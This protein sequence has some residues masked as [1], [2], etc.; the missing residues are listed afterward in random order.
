MPTEP[1]VR[2]YLGANSPAGFYSLYDEL[3][4]PSEARR[5]LILKGG[6]GCGKST[7]MGQVARQ[8]EEKGLSV[9]YI[10]CSGDPDSLDAIVLPEKRAAVVDGTAPHVVEPRLPGVVERYVNLGDCY[11]F[12][13]LSARRGELQE[14]MKGYKECYAG[15]YRC[16]TA[17]AELERNL[18]GMVTTAEVEAKVA[19][20]AAGVARREL[21]KIHGEPGRVVRRFLSAVTH[22]GVL[23]EY[24]TVEKLC[25]RIYEL[26]DTFGLGHPFL[27]QLLERAVA[28]GYDVIA[29][30]S[31]MEPQRL[32]HLIVPGLSLGFVTSA[33]RM[34]YTGRPCR[35]VH[36]D[37]MADREAVRGNRARLRFGRKVAS[38]LVD[39]AVE[40]LAQAKKR[41]D[42]LEAIYNPYVDFGQ[43]RGMA[44]RAAEELL[45]LE[46]VSAAAPSG[47]AAA[48]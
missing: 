40:H 25:K 35:R 41:H 43:V 47:A 42:L 34:Q 28:A 20:R 15:A 24:E 27:T 45:S 29:C 21:R 22:R 12:Q 37:A 33:P 9:E 11:D 36:L 13:G 6:A 39:E 19:K 23:C 8:A 17:A 46:T 5:I 32:E 14:A 18:R 7:L 48:P 31:P 4:D 44:T 1:Q 30:P 10:P 2:F 16:L 38:A 26:D 3:I